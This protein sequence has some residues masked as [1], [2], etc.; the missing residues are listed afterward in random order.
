MH[1]RAFVNRARRKRPPFYAVNDGFV[2]AWER[3][4]RM[5]PADGTRLIGLAIDRQATQ[6]SGAKQDAEIGP[7]IS[8]CLDR[9]AADTNAPG[10]D[11]LATEMLVE[12]A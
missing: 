5:T 1:S 8:N 11:E 3:R 10:Q 4:G 6:P 2:E 12:K 9:L 7:A